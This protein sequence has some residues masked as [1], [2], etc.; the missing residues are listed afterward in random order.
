MPGLGT[1]FPIDTMCIGT[2][3]VPGTVRVVF[4]FSRKSYNIGVVI[5]F[6]E[7]GNREK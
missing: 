3:K 1:G 2:G 4:N 7:G 5:N 6:V